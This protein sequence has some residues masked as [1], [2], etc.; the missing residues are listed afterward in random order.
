[1]PHHT[2]HAN[3]FRG[4]LCSQPPAAPAA[5]VPKASFVAARSCKK[6]SLENRLSLNRK[7][8]LFWP[9]PKNWLNRLLEAAYLE[10][11]NDLRFVEP[12]D[13]DDPPPF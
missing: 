8:L 5:P 4:L 1:M 9:E 6:A 10:Y 11:Q 3:D 13:E 2:S 7:Q 12:E